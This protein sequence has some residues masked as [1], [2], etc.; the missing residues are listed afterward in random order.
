MP[1]KFKLEDIVYLK[2]TEGYNSLGGFYKVT[3][4][5]SDGTIYRITDKENSFTDAFENEIEP[6]LYSVFIHKDHKT[7]IIVPLFDAPLHLKFLTSEHY[8]I[9]S[10]GTLF[11]CSTK[12]VELL[13]QLD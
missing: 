5:N 13:R 8:T 2:H 12:Q 4:I 9:V 7:P 6:P 11:E 10:K 1:Y 3:E